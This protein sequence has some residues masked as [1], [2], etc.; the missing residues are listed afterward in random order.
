MC[1]VRRCRDL[2]PCA[3]FV[4]SSLKLAGRGSSLSPTAEAMRAMGTIVLYCHAF[5]QNEEMKN[6][7]RKM[8]KRWRKYVLWMLLPVLAMLLANMPEAKA[9]ENKAAT[10]QLTKTE[11]TVEISGSSGKSISLIDNMRLYNGYR[12]ETMEESYAWINLDKT[13]LAKLDAVS[14]ASVRKSGKKL[15]ILAEAGNLFFN[16]TEPLEEEESLNI[17]VST[18]VV[19]I[20]G[21]CG[22]IE[23]LNEREVQLTLLEGTVEVS[24]IDP[25]TGQ[26]KK[27]IVT[28]GETVVCVVYEQTKE[29]D[30]C[31]ILRKQCKK[32]DIRGFVLAELLPDA[33]LVEDI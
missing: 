20:R 7:R 19:G 18:M 1:V 21:T 30:K 29:G 5:P 24:V 11:G 9:A 25:V 13:K 4:V 10:M 22:W 6:T 8:M 32:E 31:D 2:K 12:M 33:G 28:A 14:E 15:E 3:V 16:V 27:E 17:R 23:I 26:V